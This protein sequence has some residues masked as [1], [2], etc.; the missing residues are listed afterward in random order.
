MRVLKTMMRSPNEWC[1]PFIE[2]IDEDSYKYANTW[3]IIDL[4]SQTLSPDCGGRLWRVLDQ[5]VPP[6]EHGGFICE[7]NIVIGD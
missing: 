6:M 1:A 2:H 5:E 4:D 3:I 7:H